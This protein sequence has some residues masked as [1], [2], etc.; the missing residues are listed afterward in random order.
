M[1]EFD[2]YVRQ[3]LTS[4]NANVCINSLGSDMHLPPVFKTWFRYTDIAAPDILP[5]LDSFTHRLWPKALFT[6]LRAV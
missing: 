1:S 6:L 5:M 3:N 2:V 4:M